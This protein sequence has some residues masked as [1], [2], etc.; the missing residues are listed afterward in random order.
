MLEE[1][2][3]ATLGVDYA[4][5]VG[6]GGASAAAGTRSAFGAIDAIGGGAGAAVVATGG[7]TGG[8]N[9]NGF[10]ALAPVS[11]LQGTSGGIGGS[12]VR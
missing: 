4:V 8:R 5:S 1:K 7:S 2:L 12:S 9:H 10:S 11:T 3:T 6:A